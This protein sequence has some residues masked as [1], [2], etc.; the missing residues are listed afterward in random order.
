MPLILDPEDWPLWLGE[1]GTG[2]AALM[3][4]GPEDRLVFH[5]VGREVN[6]NRASGPGLIEAVAA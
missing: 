2:A 3:K 1:T 6:S 5:R 4:P